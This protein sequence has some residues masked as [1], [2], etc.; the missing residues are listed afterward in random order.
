MFYLNQSKEIQER[1][2]CY[3]T[4]IG[5]L[6]RLFT[7]SGNLYLDSRISE[8]VFCEA[9]GAYNTSRDDS[10]SDANINRLGIGIKTFLHQSSCYQKI[11]EFNRLRKDYSTLSDEDLMHFL[12]FSRNERI[13]VTQ[14]TYDLES[15]IYHFV[16]KTKQ[17]FLI[18]E[19]NMR[20]INTDRLQLVKTSPTSLVFKDDM[21][22]YN[23]NRSKS[24]LQMR[25]EPI[26]PLERVKIE[27]IENPLR[28]LEESFMQSEL[29]SSLRVVKDPFS[30]NEVYLPLYSTKAGTYG[31]VQK[32]SA[33]NQWCAS[34]RKRSFGE[35]YIPVPQEIHKINPTFF[36]DRD[37]CFRLELP[38]RKT[39]SVKLC[40]DNS[41]A[42]MSD[43]NTDLG[44]WLIE[45]IFN[46]KIEE[47]PITRNDL[48][49]RG[50]DAVK[51]WKKNE[52]T[53]AI[54]FARIGSFEE[55]ILSNANASESFKKLATAWANG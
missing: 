16:T 9:F 41:K 28:F 12:A 33:L 5:K 23:F 17:E 32:R 10:T 46:R 22:T 21:E 42:L 48:E 13:R 15:L 25:F 54:D 44:E 36:P 47:R 11:A 4:L 18:H 53:Y 24:V 30:N 31:C 27:V 19:Q 50:F 49:I 14:A 6:S 55:F 29:Q 51:I 40:Q 20:S 37:K 35:A 3:L 26:D 45:G 8:I 39:L 43:P 1:Y 34:G 7:I 2:K 52:R 38:N